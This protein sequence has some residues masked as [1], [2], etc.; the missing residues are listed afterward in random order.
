M[1][2]RWMKRRKE[3]RNTSALSLINAAFLPFRFLARPD[4]LPRRSATLQPRRA[5]PFLFL[6][7]R[8]PAS[9]FLRRCSHSHAEQ[10]ADEQP[11]ERPEALISFLARLRADQISGSRDFYLILPDTPPPR[12]VLASPAFIP[13][14]HARRFSPRYGP[15]SVAVSSAVEIQPT[16]FCHGDIPTATV[17]GNES[18]GR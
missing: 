11:T 5:P 2:R 18:P 13:R 10:N 12:L 8:L 16:R 7:P 6:P 14:H 15:Y 9:P 4:V 3:K 1:A 17:R